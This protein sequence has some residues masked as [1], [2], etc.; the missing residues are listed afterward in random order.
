MK[1]ICY[2]CSQ[3]DVVKSEITEIHVWNGIPAIELKL[4]CGHGVFIEVSK[5]TD[6][7][8][9]ERYERLKKERREKQP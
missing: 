3:K 8:Y 2:K 5:V 7:T 1:T 6:E 4:S 9:S